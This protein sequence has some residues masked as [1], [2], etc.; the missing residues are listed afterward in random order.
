[1]TKT[2]ATSLPV[3]NTSLLRPSASLQ[4]STSEDE[5][6]DEEVRNRTTSIVGNVLIS[7]DF[8][9][10]SCEDLTAV[11]TPL[12]KTIQ[13]HSNGNFSDSELLSDRNRENPKSKSHRT[14][15]EIVQ[16][17]HHQRAPQRKTSKVAVVGEWS[18]SSAQNKRSRPTAYDHLAPREQ[19]VRLSHSVTQSLTFVPSSSGLSNMIAQPTSGSLSDISEHTSRDSQHRTPSPD[20]A[21]LARKEA[22]FEW[23]VKLMKKQHLYE[24]VDLPD[25]CPTN[26]SRSSSPESCSS[27]PQHQE[28]VNRYQR[29][30]SYTGR[31][32]SYEDVVS[33]PTESQDFRS[34]SSTPEAPSDWVMVSSQLPGHSSTYPSSVHNKLVEGLSNATRKPLPLQQVE[35][36][37]SVEDTNKELDE[38][39]RPKVSKKPVPTPRR[40]QKREDVIVTNQQSSSTKQDSLDGDCT[41]DNTASSDDSGSGKQPQVLPSSLGVVTSGSVTSLSEDRLPPALPPKPHSEHSLHFPSLP[42]IP[43]KPRD[44]R[45]DP[46][47]MLVDIGNSSTSATLPVEMKSLD[48]TRKRGER[49]VYAKISHLKTEQLGN[50]IAERNK[51]KSQQN[52][53]Q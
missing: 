21:V 9:T 5:D 2:E 4:N 47:Y 31:F 36:G 6:G 39:G 45:C 37:D 35:F 24:D 25:D 14:H 13:D 33:V 42:R 11:V 22:T 7:S 1:M 52:R 29:K 51:A 32:H 40:G 8:N 18:S 46:N 28:M 50:M 26:I 27:L 15:V 19:Q 53:K 34:E 20:H 44:I 48:A 30:V 43:N 41:T 10:R 49:V 12:L 38:S 3:S 17:S 16:E 23:K